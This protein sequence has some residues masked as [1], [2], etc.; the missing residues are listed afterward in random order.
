MKK[1]ALALVC[2]VSVAFFASCDPT[3]ENP[4][5]AI[6]ILA[7]EGYLQDGDQIDMNVDYHFGF[8]VSSNAETQKELASL[9]IT[10]NDEE[11]ETVALSGDTYTYEG[12]IGWVFETKDYV[13][14][15]TIKAV[16]TDVAG[17]TNSASI[18]VSIY[19][20]EPL[21]ANDYEWIRKA[22]TLLDNTESEMAAVGL[23]WTGSYKEIFATI[24]PI[25]ETTKVYL[26]EDALDQFNA[27][28]TVNDL[29]N[30]ITSLNETSRP[31]EKYRNVSTNSSKTYNDVLA[32]IDS[33]N[34][35]HL[36]LIGEAVIETGNYGTQ[37][38]LKGQVK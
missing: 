12:I 19:Y 4:E 36:V 35:Y 24:E 31:I 20:E 13:G 8:V 34:N 21:L 5:P 37:I 9:V 22:T 2:L 38:T 26:I 28:E 25:D 17:E 11:Y 15:A 30:C 33:Q 18:T 29:N 10:V 32:I 16:V 6:Q 3:V 23:K 27:I 1:L 14:D 7:T